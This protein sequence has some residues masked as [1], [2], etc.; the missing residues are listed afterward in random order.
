MADE[1]DAV[2]N[3]SARHAR[4]RGAALAEFAIVFPLLFLLIAAMLDYGMAFVSLNSARQGVREG[5][6]QAVVANFGTSSSCTLT[7][8]PFTE[9][10]AKLMC[11]TKGR[12]GLSESDVRI[13]VAFPGAN[14]VGNSLLVCAAYPMRSMTGVL[15]PMMNGKVMKSK[16]EMRIEKADLTLAG[17]EETALAGSDWTWCA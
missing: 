5:A 13:K 7:G 17:A 3:T 11:L 12:I 8:G 2:A 6:R 4:D 15:T 9:S 14:A 10:D 16:V 1:P